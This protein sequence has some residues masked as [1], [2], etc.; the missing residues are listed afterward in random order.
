MTLNNWR[1]EYCHIVRWVISRIEAADLFKDNKDDW[2]E[3]LIYLEKFEKEL[4]EKHYNSKTKKFVIREREWFAICHRYIKKAKKENKRKKAD[5]IF[6]IWTDL[7]NSL[8][9]KNHKDPW[10]AYDLC[11]KITKEE[12]EFANKYLI[13]KLDTIAQKRAHKNTVWYDKDSDVLIYRNNKFI[14]DNCWR[15]AHI[16]HKGKERSFSL[17]WDWWYP[18]DR[19]LDLEKGWKI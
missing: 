5:F 8:Y 6:A 3:C 16:L 9:F 2:V 4:F 7:A 18:I 13:P 12:L 1:D 15:E 11:R 17:D 10:N 14:L 19:Y